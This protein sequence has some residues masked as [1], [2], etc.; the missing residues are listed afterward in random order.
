M[1]ISTAVY[2]ESRGSR[3]A[4]ALHSPVEIVV[5]AMDWTKVA[6]RALRHRLTNRAARRSKH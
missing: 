1:V 4:C 5:E 6:S 2:R 3:A